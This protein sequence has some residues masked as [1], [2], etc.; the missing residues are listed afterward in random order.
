M[1]RAVFIALLFLALLLPYGPASASR[2]PCGDAFDNYYS[3]IPDEDM[4]AEFRYFPPGSTRVALSASL[5]LLVILGT[6]DYLVVSLWEKKE[7]MMKKSPGKP[8]A[9]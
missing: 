3:E 7:E 8:G 5:A 9:D 1:K 2:R 6:I 4:G